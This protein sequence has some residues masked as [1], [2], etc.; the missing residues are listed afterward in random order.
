MPSF[1]T[2][3]GVTRYIPGGITRV[4]AD[5]L[6]PVTLG[7]NGVVGL[8]GEAD[9]GEP[10]TLIAIDDPSRIRSTFRSGPLADAI[11]LAFS[12]S[13]D[14]LIPGGASRVICYKTNAGTRATIALPSA[15]A[16]V[17][18][19]STAT[20]GG[21]STLIDTTLSATTL[22]D[23]FNGMKIILRPNT[24]T[25]EVATVSDYVASTGTF[26]VSAPWGS[27]PVAAEAYRVLDNTDVVVGEVDAGASTTTVPVVG[28]TF[29]VNEHAGRWVVLHPALGPAVTRQI[30]S[31]TTTTLTVSPAMPSAPVAST[32]WVEIL[33]ESIVLTSRDYGV[34]TNGLL[35]DIATAVSGAKVAT[36]TF[37]GKDEISP[38][39]GN[40]PF[41]K[42]IFKGSPVAVTNTVAALSTTT[43][44]NLTTGGLTINAHK[45]AQV[46]IDG[47]YTK[48]VSNTASALTVSP[49]LS[50][51]P[52]ATT[53]VTVYNASTAGASSVIVGASGVATGL[54]T[55]TNV[56]GA[57]LNIT[58]TAGQ[59]LNQLADQINLNVNYEAV[60][61]DG[62]NGDTFLCKDFDFGA[63]TKIG[64]LVSDNLTTEAF[65][66]DTM[67]MVNY[68]NQVS[69]LVTA[70]RSTDGTFG[71]QMTVGDVGDAISFSG[72]TRGISSNTN[73][74]DGFDALLNVRV[75]HVVPL[76]DE[77]LVNEGY[78]S[79][80]TVASV[81]Q[82]LR[83]HVVLCRGA[84]GSERGGYIGLKGTKSAIIA[85][86]A[87]LNDMDVHLVGQ[88]PT[89]LNLSGSLQSFG[90]RM[91][92]VL[93]AG[94]RAGAGEV[95]EALTRKQLK[96]AGITS[97]SSWDARDVT[98]ANDMIKAG[99]LFA[100]TDDT[101]V[102]RWVRDLTTWISD[103]NLAYSEGSIRDVVRFIAYGLRTTLV[104]RYVG[105]K[106]APATIRN[107]KNT[108]STFL[109]QARTDNL[110]VDSID[111]ATG[112]KMYAYHSMKLIVTGDT[113]KLCVGF[114]P[115]P[116][117]NFVLNDLSLGIA[118]QSV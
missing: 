61:P 56:L 34:H 53:P 46:L 95:G 64:I 113:A 11:N 107:V 98:D 14:P 69:Q 88:S 79:T 12:P 50:A 70:V 104:E 30:V 75:N 92:A 99:V 42:L 78:G 33:P 10:G 87:A 41:F 66:Q 105:R 44:I 24:A 4:G 116:S 17:V 60:I 37:E 81:A 29:T 112:A 73:F 31:N 83:S 28:A 40:V 94:S 16:E 63:S 71:G 26:T 101:G 93:A 115:V 110:I 45:G 51:A 111:P 102:T 7:Q 58:F 20:G 86:A 1:V 72:G 22:D 6:V 43:L 52:V 32:T 2:F 8:I 114:F 5:A 103:N 48:V 47:E 118:I 68:F 117:I 13:N 96:V 106:A 18:V 49:A 85:Q 82:Q 89:L 108:A 80:A 76:I 74:Q 65:K 100:R 77:N 91:Q 15:P 90:P 9:G 55:T 97:D 59:T 109:E 35:V 84:V 19:T 57:D 67:Q 25:Q 21:A 54:T 23:Q 62:V 36:I 3:N 39:V 38:E 27:I